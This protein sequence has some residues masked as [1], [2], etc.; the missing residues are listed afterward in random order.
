MSRNT[1]LGLTLLIAGCASP[2]VPEPSLTGD[3]TYNA[4]ALHSA[5]NSIVCNAQYLNLNVRQ[6][7]H[8]FVG[9]TSGGTLLCTVN[10]GLVLE[11]TISHRLVARGLLVEGIVRF[12]IGPAMGWRHEGRMYNSDIMEGTVTFTV[13]YTSSKDPVLLT[14][15][16]T[17][18][19][20]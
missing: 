9:T 13:G 18:V 20:Y 4:I 12:D 11:D 3:W 7:G 15:P 10:G 5:D 19:R 1:A 2:T 17:A 8:T 14:G 16:F 6:S